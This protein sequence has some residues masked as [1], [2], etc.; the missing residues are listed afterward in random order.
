METVLT[1]LNLHVAAARFHLCG[2][3]IGWGVFIRHVHTSK[4]VTLFHTFTLKYILKSLQIIHY[5]F[6][7][8]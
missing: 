4:V 2:W 3:Q 8:K 5:S 6:K 7:R 1:S